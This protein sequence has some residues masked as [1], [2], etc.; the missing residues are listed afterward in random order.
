MINR[1]VQIAGFLVQHKWDDAHQVAF[2]ADF[3]PRRYARL[4]KDDGRHAIL[5]DADPDQKTPQFLAIAKLLAELGISAPAILAADPGTGLALLEDFGDLNVG[6]L[7]EAGEDPTPFFSRA[8][9]LLIH[10]H[11]TF[12]HELVK[13]VGLPVFDVTLFSE[14]VGLYLD[15]Y[16]PLQMDRDASQEE[17]QTFKDAWRHALSCIS[18]L[19]QSLLLRDYMPDNLMHLPGRESFRSLGV[20][21]F[22]DAGLGPVAYDLASLAEVVRRDV[23]EGLLEEIVALYHQ[24]MQ[25]ACSLDALTAAAVVLSAQRHTRILGIVI[26]LAQKGRSEKL[27]YL[28]RIRQHLALRLQNP[29]L[30]PVADWFNLYSPL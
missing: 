17:R 3:S 12:R 5:M 6:K 21:D 2:D 20:L 8:V 16:F 11:R 19:P 7:L 1:G 26:R 10:L 30:R 23:R 22:Q 4:I 27:A 13:D 14:Q 28:P 18:S 9:E 24:K 25:P 15:T 29:A